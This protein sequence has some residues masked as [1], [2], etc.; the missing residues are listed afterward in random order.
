MFSHIKFLKKNGA[1]KEHKTYDDAIQNYLAT[2]VPSGGEMFL[3]LQNLA[4]SSIAS[5]VNQTHII[6]ILTLVEKYQDGISSYT[7]LLYKK[8]HSRAP[9]SVSPIWRINQ[10]DIEI[11][12]RKN[13]IVFNSNNIWEFIY[14]GI[15]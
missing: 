5:T 14:F 7:R 12:D 8:I 2:K 11:Y 13:K 15:R 1:E 4:G 6:K 3:G 10:R 9:M